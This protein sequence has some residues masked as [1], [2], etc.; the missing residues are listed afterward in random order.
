MGQV[1]D[2]AFGHF[3]A[4]TLRDNQV[5]VSAL[6]FSSAARTA[7]AFVSLKVDGER[8]FM[9]YRHPAPTCSTRPAK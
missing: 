6:R 4:N 2:D 9:F 8:D 7:L 3:L 5:D 1:G